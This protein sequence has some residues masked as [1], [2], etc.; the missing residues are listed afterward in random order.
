MCPRVPEC[1]HYQEQGK[2]TVIPENMII[3][4]PSPLT[5]A[6]DLAVRD[7]KDN[8]EIYIERFKKWLKK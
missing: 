6:L 3:S 5:S 1:G 2:T 7:L 8:G 4:A